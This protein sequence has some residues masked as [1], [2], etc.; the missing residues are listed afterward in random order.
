MAA[1]EEAPKSQANTDSDTKTS[2]NV[3]CEEDGS[4]M[5]GPEEE[6]HYSAYEMVVSKREM[7]RARTFRLMIAGM[8]VM[9]V[10]V[11]ILAFFLLS[12][13]ENR[14]FEAAVSNREENRVY[15]TEA[16]VL[17]PTSLFH[18]RIGH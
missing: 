18:E 15:Q 10:V 16:K 7:K 13:Q 8:L 12:G 5:C 4:G 17:Q 14:N 1:L 2:D 6:H 11:T 3:Q 9:T